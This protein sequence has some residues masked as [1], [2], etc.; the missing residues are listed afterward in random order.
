MP[1]ANCYTLTNCGYPISLIDKLLPFSIAVNEIPQTYN[2]PT[3][4]AAY[5]VIDDIENYNRIDGRKE[6]CRL[7]TEIYGINEMSAPRNKA[8]LCLLRLRHNRR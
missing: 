8:I 5:R 3:S 1:A 4:A 7:A 6:I 2:L